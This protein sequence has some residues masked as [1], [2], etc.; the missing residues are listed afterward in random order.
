MTDP[1]IIDADAQTPVDGD[2]LSTGNGGTSSKSPDDDP[3]QDAIED[4][5]KSI[6]SSDG[7]GAGK[8]AGG[9]NKSI[10][11]VPV[12]IQVIIGSTEMTVS[13]LMALEPNA[14]VTLD[15][16]IG[17][18]VD[19]AVNGKKIGEGELEVNAQDPNSLCIRITKLGD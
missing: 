12:E 9:Y 19:I 14:V 4:L 6:D 3:L 1:E 18:P 13:E 8:R 7:H 11:D 5:E 10:Y 17:E 16:K 2:E 15:S